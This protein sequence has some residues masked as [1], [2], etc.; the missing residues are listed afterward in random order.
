MKLNRRYI[1]GIRENLSF[2]TST[3]ILTA[4]TLAMFFIFNIAG[5]A[6]LDFSEVFF[7]EH[8]LEDAHFVTY[9][10]ISDEDISELEK[11]YDLTLERQQYVNIT[12]DGVTARVFQK[13]ESLD[14]Y[15]ITVGEDVQND[16][17]IIISE[18]YADNMGIAIG[19]HI[20][21]GLR[22]YTVT[23][24]FQRPDYLYMLENEDDSYKNISTFFLAYMTDRAFSNLGDAA[25][26][27]LVKYNGD[28]SNDFRSEINDSYY[29]QSYTAAEQ[30]TRILMVDSQA[31]MF[32]ILSY[33][34][35]AV[36][37]L[38][39]VALIGIIISRKV[40]NEQRMIGTLSALGYTS[41]RLELHY[42]GF[43]AIPGL[44]GGILLTVISE[45][46]AQPFCEIGLMD[47][48]PMRIEGHLEPLSAALAI[49]IPTA[50]YIAATLHSV[51]KLLKRDTVL[52][53]AGKA[54]GDKRK[55][56]RAMAGSKASFRTKYAVRS[57][58][59]NPMRGFV[60]FMGVFLGAVMTFFSF[61]MIDSLDALVDDVSNSLG[62]YKYEYILNSL[63]TENSYGG[64]EILVGS[65][66]SETQKSVTL[67]G[68]DCDNPYLNFNGADG[69]EV[70]VRD[71]Y[72]VTSYAALILGWSEGDSVTVYNSGTLEEIEITVAGVINNDIQ[73]AI[74]TSRESAAEL[75]GYDEEVFNAIV[76]DEKLSIPSGSVTKEFDVSSISEQIDTI[77]EMMDLC[78]LTMTI[79]GVIICIAS[80]YVAVNMMVTENRNNISMLKVLGYN[81][82]QINRIVLNVNHI[83][84]PLGII[85]ALPAVYGICDFFFIAMADMF[86][87][88]IK[89]TI[90][91]KS[92]ILPVLITVA[93][94][95]VSLLLV[96]RKVKNTD[97]TESLKDTRE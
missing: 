59:G 43:A 83:F 74:F 24:Y 10:P 28:N 92:C 17:D 96:R 76:S 79:I 6:I 95:F 40:K 50:L 35:L 18:G 70:D 63:E 30:N 9:L 15:E 1:R 88:L 46:F 41:L 58:L 69:S 66:E 65:L 73:L 14:T 86:G 91:L 32:I 21:V 5:N 13:T 4:M 42:A 77:D 55:L 19:Q 20:K 3:T 44:L 87:M 71:G 68:S 39:A 75:L 16:Y 22:T 62:S 38:I 78:I 11:K 52:L 29:M 45:V 64:E 93:C 80:V 7:E 72:Y 89:A 8:G 26:S 81:D 54:E 33:V 94:Y 23:G 85:C 48:E 53:L 97:M 25:C 12:T 47:Y 36:A 34:I 27:Y 84:L 31:E 49:V 56:K 51:R 90:N 82:R 57:L 37:P 67:V 2:Y 61:V 60:V